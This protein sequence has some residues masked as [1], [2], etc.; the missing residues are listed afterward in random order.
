MI[1]SKRMRRTG[2]VAPMEEERKAYTILGKKPKEKRPLG[3]PRRE[4]DNN[5]K[6]DLMWDRM[7]RTDLIWPKTGASGRPLWAQ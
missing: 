1:R 6:V 7:V 4:S 5:I 3:R 2:Y